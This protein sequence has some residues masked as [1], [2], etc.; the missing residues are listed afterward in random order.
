MPIL[1]QLLGNALAASYTP[2]ANSNFGVNPDFYGFDK[3]NQPVDK[4]G[5]PTKMYVGGTPYQSPTFWNKTFSPSEASRVQDINNQYTTMPGMMGAQAKAQE[6]SARNTWID[7]MSQDPNIG[8]EVQANPA[9]A[10]AKYGGHAHM[11]PVDWNTQSEAA[12]NLAA[13]NPSTK[14]AAIHNTLLAQGKTSANTANTADVYNLLGGPTSQGTAEALGAQHS[15]NVNAGDVYRDPNTEYNK[16]LS[17]GLGTTQL[18]GDINAQPARNAQAYNT[19][20]LGANISGQ[21]L[22]DSPYTTGA[23]HDESI[24]GLYH[25][26]NP[27]NLYPS[28]TQG[29]VN[30][31]DSLTLGGVPMQNQ[32]TR[33]MAEQTA[34]G[35]VHTLPDSG[36]KIVASKSPNKW[37][38][39]AIHGTPIIN[40]VQDEAAQDI[41]D[42]HNEAVDAHHNANEAEID[43]QIAQLKAKKAQAKK[44]KTSTSLLGHPDIPQSTQNILDS[45]TQKYIESPEQQKAREWQE[46]EAQARTK[47]GQLLGNMQ[48]TY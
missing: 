39:Q 44:Q 18:L 31:D 34:Q 38:P 43:A 12:A 16:D 27:D 17:T 15:M 8:P 23:M 41:L 9:A 36:L 29:H 30:P 4:D 33:Q 24:T 28:Y 22:Q 1:G 32:M 46:Q 11:D 2:Q 25:A 20:N 6:I 5:N 35:N 3:N 7:R 14:A 40:G 45:Y 19:A 37:T 48:R 47:M 21:Q 10:W 13:N 26:Q 42:R